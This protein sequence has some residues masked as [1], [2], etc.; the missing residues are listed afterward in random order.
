MTTSR[1]AQIIE[2][3]NLLVA[4]VTA[5]SD[6]ELAAMI[7]EAE[8]ALESLRDEYRAWVTEDL[9][10]LKDAFEAAKAEPGGAG[11]RLDAVFRIAHEMKGQGETFEYDLVTEIGASLCR[12]LE[13]VA[14][15]GPQELETAELH[16]D[17]LSAVVGGRIMG[18]GGET[19]RKLVLGLDAAVAKTLAARP[20][21]QES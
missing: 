14:E 11:R 6:G 10:K 3:P 9:A 1:K 2:L 17:A 8:A 21:R 5:A 20:P 15:I 12:F 18:D 19:G 7:A 13:R 16:L 4:K